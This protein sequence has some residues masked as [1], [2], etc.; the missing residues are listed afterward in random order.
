MS[1]PKG[2]K[3]EK[4]HGGFPKEDREFEKAK[5]QYKEEILPLLAP[6]PLSKIMEATAFS[7]RYASMIRR[8]LYTPHPMHY[9]KLETLISMYTKNDGG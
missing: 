7:K 2:R 8:D 9:Q 6:V 5:Q 3:N 1:E 4:S